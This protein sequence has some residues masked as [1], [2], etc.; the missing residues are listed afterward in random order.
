MEQR[1]PWEANISS[2]S[3]EIPLILWNTKVHYSIHKSPQLRL[4]RR[5]SPISRLLWLRRKMIKF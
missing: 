5:I 2:A 1:P 4:Y 3:Q